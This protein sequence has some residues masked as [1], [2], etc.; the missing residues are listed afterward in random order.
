M[1]SNHLIFL[2]LLFFI[3]L[4]QP[5]AAEVLVIVHPDNPVNQ[6]SREQVIDIYMGRYAN[7]SDGHTALAYDLAP[8][9]PIR[10]AYYQKLVNKSVA[11]VNAYWSRLLFS[12]RATPPLALPDA[13]A[14][15]QAI[16]K[17]RDAIGYI[18]SQYL[19]DKVK[20]VFRLP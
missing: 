3:A 4:A 18:D 11:Q 8:D 13:K 15:S 17:N 10:A 6:L 9:S 5:V 7:F 2:T 16:L 12:G 19:V 1:R 14:V 20:V